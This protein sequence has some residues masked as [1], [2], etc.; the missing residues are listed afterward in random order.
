MN[1]LK[2]GSQN[3]LDQLFRAYPQ[4]KHLEQAIVD[5]I[6]AMKRSIVAGG[7]IFLCGNG[8]SAADAEH[9]VGELMKSFMKKRPLPSEVREKFSAIAGDKADFIA[10][11]LEGS[12]RAVSL[13]SGVSLPTALANDTSAELIF[14]QQLYGLAKEGDIL[15]SISTSGNAQNVI[16]ALYVAKAL[17]CVSIGLT[18]KTG[19][20][21]AELVD[22]EIRAPHDSTP[23]VQELHLPIYHCICAILEEELF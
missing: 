11:N 7:T 5:A 1:E 8:G 6:L 13:V 19:G 4:I 22:I 10:D 23:I 20:K 2:I 9:I 12:I 16:N 14:A 17:G 21:M 15:F 18:G 3:F